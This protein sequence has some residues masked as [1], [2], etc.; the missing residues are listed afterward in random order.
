MAFHWNN[1]WHF[2]RLDNGDVQVTRRLP[3]QEQAFVDHKQVT[4]GHQRAPIHLDSD[5]DFL[6]V[7][8]PYVEIERFVI[9]A[10]E[11]CS[12]VTSMCKGLE[13][14]ERYDTVT[15]LHGI[16]KT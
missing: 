9:P 16:T 8:T 12:L 1:G 13:T 2:E 6:A 3:V 4:R 10:M 5:K 7:G 14:G 15:K 11:W